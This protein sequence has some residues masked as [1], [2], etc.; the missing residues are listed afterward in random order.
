[1]Q[2]GKCSVERAQLVQRCASIAVQL[3]YAIGVLSVYQC[4]LLP[5]CTVARV[6]L[7]YAI[8]VLSVYQCTLL[9]ICTVARVQLLYVI[10]VLSVYQCTLLPICT[11]A[12]VQLLYVIGDLTI[13]ISAHTVTNTYSISQFLR[14]LP[15][16]FSSSTG[17]SP[18]ATLVA[19][20]INS[21][22]EEMLRLCCFTVRRCLQDGKPNVKRRPAALLLRQ[23]SQ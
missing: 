19:T 5:I 8:G 21:C 18:S 1:M 3:L 13:T 10:G 16:L 2:V 7:L 17:T 23:S 11:V 12:R 9:P 14:T 15:R 4:T 20:V 22:E 6:Q